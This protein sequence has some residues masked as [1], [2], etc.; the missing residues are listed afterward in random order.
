M[1]QYK[2]CILLLVSIIVL[3][4][5][6]SIFIRNNNESSN[7][8]DDEEYYEN[9]NQWDF[10]DKAVYINLD[11]R[12]DRKKQITKELSNKIPQNKVIRFSAI[13]HRFGHIGCTMSHIKVLEMAIKNN[14]KNILIIEDDAMFYKYDKG[15]NQLLK[16]ITNDPNF[17]VITL[18]NVGADF[19]KKTGKLYKA[20]TTTAYIVNNHYYNT[21]LKNFKEGLMNLLETQYME[22][23]DE[24]HEHENTYCID[25][26]WKRIQPIHNW[27]IVN[28]ALMIQRPSKSTIL[29]TEVD[30]QHLFNI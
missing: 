12:L 26:Y 29:N 27:Y 4:I 23:Q 24:R 1:K 20:Q 11:N 30:Y 18:G 6:F 21:L 25:Q 28:P 2:N 8:E 13:K 16:L 17:D 7:N 9:I 10:L 19:D 5:L 15:Y 14:W 3:V 22:D